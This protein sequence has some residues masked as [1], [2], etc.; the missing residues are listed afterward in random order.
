MQ[1]NYQDCY[2]ILIQDIEIDCFLGVYDRE[3]AR[4]RPVVID[5]EMYVPH[6]TKISRRD[7]LAETVN[8]ER[9]VE[10]VERVV[11]DR[12][13]KLVETLCGELADDIARLP[14]LRA[15]KVS[16]TKPQPL[17]RAR[18]VRVEVWRHP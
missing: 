17:P 16:V 2:R 11:A 1:D 18:S 6:A 12:R 14:G 3:Q 10:A 13:F 9:V 8:Y 7:T 5:V 4:R 15:L